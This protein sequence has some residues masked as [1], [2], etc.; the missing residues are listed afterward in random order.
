M[1]RKIN[2]VN[3]L[4]DLKDVHHCLRV[5][6]TELRRDKYKVGVVVE[7]INSLMSYEVGRIVLYET[8]K[9]SKTIVVER[10]M[11]KKE[12]ERQR[13]KKSLLRTTGTI[14]GVPKKYVLDISFLFRV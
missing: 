8:S 6:D 9:D 11:T 14:V 12:I 2:L 3:T 5:M 7:P 4:K 1:K 10:A 13:S